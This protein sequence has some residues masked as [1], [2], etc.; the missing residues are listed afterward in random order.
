MNKICGIYQIL[1]K[2]NNHFYIGSSSNVEWRFYIHKRLLRKGE[3]FN[4]HLQ[5]AWNK[6]GEDS[7]LF[8]VLKSIPKSNCLAE[9]QKMLDQHHGKPY[10]YNMDKWAK[11]NDDAANK[12]RSASLVGRKRSDDIRQK[13]SAAQKNRKITQKILDGRKKSGEALIRYRAAHKEEFEKNRI[14][15]CIGRKQPD[16]FRKIMSEKMRGRIVSDETKLKISISQ[17]GI[18]KSPRTKEHQEKLNAAQRGKKRSAE[19]CEKLRLALQKYYSVPEHRI[20]NSERIKAYHQ[21][22]L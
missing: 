1:N 6:Y 14:A 11:L 20:Q 19:T 5:R 16:S 7:F 22:K 8:S 3:H 21:N 15:A 12:K 18:P 4:V 2:T 13:M 10:F 9:E 17:K